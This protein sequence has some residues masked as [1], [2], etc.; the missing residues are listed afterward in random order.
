MAERIAVLNLKCQWVLNRNQDDG[1]SQRTQVDR[2][3]KAID[4]LNPV[5]FIAVESGAEIENGAWLGP[6]KHHNWNLHPTA[7]GEFVHAHSSLRALSAY[8]PEI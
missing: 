8:K 3:G 4:E 6:A 5:D 2:T 7:V 1:A